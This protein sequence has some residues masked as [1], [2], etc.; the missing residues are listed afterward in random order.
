MMIKLRSVHILS[1]A[2]CALCSLPAGASGQSNR[3]FGEARNRMVDMAVVASGVE[4]PRVIAAMRAVPRHNFV[5]RTQRR[6][7]YLDRALPIGFGQTISPPFIVAMM[8]EQLDPQ[9]T[10]RVLEIGTGSG[11]QAS[12]LGQLVAEVFSI[13]IVE[14]LG[15]KAE[16]TI[17]RLGY[18]NIFTRVGDGYLGWPEFAP[19]DKIIVTCSPE[20]VPQPLIDQLVEGGRMIVPVGERYQQS[21][22]LYRKVDGKLVSEEIETTFFVPMTGTAEDLR[23]KADPALPEI[24]NGS[25]EETFGKADQPAGWYY[26]RNGEV[27]NDA[28]APDG[29]KRITFSNTEPGRMCKALQAFGVDGQQ[30]AAIDVSYSMRGINIEANNSTDELPRLV[31]EYYDVDRVPV[32]QDGFPAGYGTF[33]WTEQRAR[34]RVPPRARLAVMQIGIYGAFGEVSFDDVRVTAAGENP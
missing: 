25:F 10:D 6:D 15:R 30:V 27:E 20:K 28:D 1:A 33:D 18:E 34:L 4:N 14:P 3:Q 26:L 29:K 23:E 21:L 22:Y 24:A 13:E 32:G 2:V 12:V 8:T 7:A 19:F 17:K 11:Y 16:R 5:A 31:I 9:P